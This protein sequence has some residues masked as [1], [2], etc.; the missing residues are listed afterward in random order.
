MVAEMRDRAWGASREPSR[1]ARAAVHG[2]DDQVFR[3]LRAGQRGLPWAYDRRSGEFAQTVRRADGPDGMTPRREGTSLRYAAIAAL[4]IGRLDLGDQRAVLAGATA[5]DLVCATGVRAEKQSDPGAVALAAW[6]AAEVSGADDQ[7][8]FSRLDAEL[9]GGRPLPTVDLSWML[10]AAVA[11]GGVGGSL[12]VAEQATSRLLD[13]QG[14]KGIFPHMSPAGSQNRWRR[15]VGSFADQVYPIQALAR[16]YRVSGDP[17]ALDAAEATAQ[18]LCELQGPAGQWW[19]HYDMRTGDVVE[20]FPVYSVHQHAMAPMALFDLADAGGTDRTREIVG[21]LRWLDSHPEVDEEL[22]VDRA[23]W[24]KVGRREPAKAARKLS[25]VTTAVRRGW[26]VPGLDRAFPADR[27]DHECR[28]Y[29]LGWLLY[30]WLPAR[31]A[32]PS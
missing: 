15:H 24:R 31:A 28:P 26:H 21:G 17:V 23:I 25:A 20:R 12:A 8:L 4:G 14:A 9:S 6:A 18:R 27:V 19:W 29:E 2:A 7:R 3:L 13:T 22:V 11:A 1:I 5:A 10:T 16:A 30:A 32:A